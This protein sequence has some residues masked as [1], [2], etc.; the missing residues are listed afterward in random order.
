LSSAI[1]YLAIVAIWACV[2]IPRWL[3]RSASSASGQEHRAA[4]TEPDAADG[5]ADE[6]DATARDARH[7]PSVPDR[8]E[9]PDTD[10]PA[11]GRERAGHAAARARYDGGRE[12]RG[13]RH[14][15]P[16][17]P[18]ADGTRRRIL[19]ARRRL[20]GMLLALVVAA[21][22]LAWLRLAAW[23]VV[24]PPT[25]MMAGY[26]LVL[27]EAAHADAKESRRELAAARAAAHA[28]AQAGA[29]RRRDAERARTAPVLDGVAAHATE[30]AGAAPNAEI[31]DI[32][33][34]A[35][36]EFYDQYVDAKLRAVGD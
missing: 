14:P 7:E 12:T 20:L 22:M 8:G 3:R 10:R 34:R 1:L 31:I 36:E 23:W 29:A 15:R 9:R 27:R 5:Q 17:G 25:I 4:D 13:T 35:D 2:L 16:A 21:G 32:S 26:L 6:R 30:R 19:A 33:E 11:A 28:R 24:L 18:P